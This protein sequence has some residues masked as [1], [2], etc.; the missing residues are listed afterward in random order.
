[1]FIFITLLF[2]YFMY[3]FKLMTKYIQKKNFL[4]YLKEN[5]LNILM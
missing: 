3:L 1:M 2:M 4:R 5:I